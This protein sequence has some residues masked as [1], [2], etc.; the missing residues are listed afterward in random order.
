[1]TEAEW[2][3]CVDLIPMLR[4]VLGESVC[5]RKRQLHRRSWPRSVPTRSIVFWLLA[6]AA[7]EEL[8]RRAWSGQYRTRTCDLAGVI[9]AL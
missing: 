6:V 9:R 5:D 8:F 3:A 4:F 2:L 7:V 1:M